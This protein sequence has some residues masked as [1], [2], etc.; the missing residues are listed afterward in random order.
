MGTTQSLNAHRRIPFFNFS[1]VSA[2]L[3]NQFQLLKRL[4][5]GSK[6][7]SK[8]RNKVALNLGY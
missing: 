3:R 5:Q 2:L 6:K 4:L 8:M 1:E 7:A